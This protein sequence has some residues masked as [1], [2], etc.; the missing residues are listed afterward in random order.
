MKFPIA[1]AALC[2][3][4]AACVKIDQTLGGSMIPVSNTYKVVSP[5]AVRIGVRQQMADS[6][7]GFSDTR[8]TVGAIR[9][10]DE[11]GLTTRSSVVTLIPL[12]NSDFDMGTDRIFQSFHFGAALDSVSVEDE[13]QAG[14]IQK[15][16]VYEA[17]RAIDYSKDYD[18]NKDFPHGSV[19]VS[20]G[21]PY[22]SGDSDSLSFNFSREFGEKYLQMTDA[23]RADY[24]TYLSRLPGIYLETSAPLGQ[25]GRINLFELQLGYDSD[26]GSITG[27]Y[28]QLNYSAVFDGERKDTSVFFYFSATGFYDLDS[29][30][31]NSGTGSFPQYCLNLT[32]HDSEKSRA[33][34]GQ[35]GEEVL[36]EGGGG[37]KPVVSAVEIRKCIMDAIRANGDDPSSAIINRATLNFNYVNDGNYDKSYKLPQILSPTCRIKGEESVA[38]M[39][40]TDAS[41][42]EENQGDRNLS[43]FTFSP[44][45]TYHAQE[46]IG[47]SDTDEGLVKG[48]YDIW[49][50]IMHNDVTTTTTSGNTELSQYYQYLAYQSYMGN[51]YGGYGGYGGYGYGGYYGSSYSNYYNYAMLAQMYASSS[52]STSTK[53][54]LDRDRYYYCRLYGPAASEEKLRPT[55]T[56]TYSVPKNK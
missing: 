20:D 35:A 32:G 7:S 16:N 50:L 42:S 29:L 17:S 41:S 18:L 52:T 21:I 47:M 34:A 40:L 24:D 15:V 3:C 30:A 55:L 51:M 44:D 37:L 4:L 23:E 9:K 53:T 22:I 39:G 5:D 13:G 1:A 2:V 27:N 26:Y 45:I 8:I 56:F 25:G 19:R 38:F 43:L 12:F 46:L 10:D 33:L 49:L 31:T 48:N 28:A 11:F 6:L 14:I 36:V 54:N